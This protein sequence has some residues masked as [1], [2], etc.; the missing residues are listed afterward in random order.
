MNYYKLCSVIYSQTCCPVTYA[1]AAEGIYTSKHVV[2]YEV[3]TVC[4][5]AMLRIGLE[6]ILLVLLLIGPVYIENVTVCNSV[7][8]IIIIIIIIIITSV[9]KITQLNHAVVWYD[10]RDVAD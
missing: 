7:S 9:T 4:A 1:T 6:D 3:E 10:S 2:T 5:L 8:V